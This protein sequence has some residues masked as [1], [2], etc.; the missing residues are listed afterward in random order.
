MGNVLPPNNSVVHK[1]HVQQMDVTSFIHDSLSLSFTAIVMSLKSKKHF[2][3]FSFN[4]AANSEWGIYA[5][6]RY[7]P[8]RNNSNNSGL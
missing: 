3:L 4:V 2:S 8:K 6:T 5:I 7:L 1:S